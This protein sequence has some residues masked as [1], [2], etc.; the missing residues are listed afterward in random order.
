MQYDLQLAITTVLSA[1]QDG[2][3]TY[4][5]LLE[6]VV[7]ALKLPRNLNSHRVVVWVLGHLNQSRVHNP[8][9]QVAPLNPTF[10]QELALHCW[11][12]LCSIDPIRS[13]F[14]SH[15]KDS[16]WH[17]IVWQLNPGVDVDA[18]PQWTGCTVDESDPIEGRRPDNGRYLLYQLWSRGG[19]N[20][21]F[22]RAN[23]QLE[24][25]KKAEAEAIAA[26]NFVND[27][28]DALADWDPNEAHHPYYRFGTDQKVWGGYF[29]RVWHWP[30]RN[31]LPVTPFVGYVRRRALPLEQLKAF[32]E[33]AQ[34]ISEAEYEQ[35]MAIAEAEAREADRHERYDAEELA[36]REQLAA[37]ARKR[38]FETRDLRAFFGQ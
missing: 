20:A 16:I 25:Q 27:H 11:G 8:E 14:L 19:L 36:W 12:G 7:K 1:L 15:R 34:P 17:A 32:V 28:I 18:V 24:E 22:E 23:V 26:E 5:H 30:H 4:A 31:C 29:A 6:C 9:I 33:T 2:P 13:D 35:G 38:I 10:E 3:K 21:F 37:E